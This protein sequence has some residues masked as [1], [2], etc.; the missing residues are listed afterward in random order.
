MSAPENVNLKPESLPLEGSRDTGEGILISIYPDVCLTP[1][2]GVM[3]AIPYT[4][5]AYQSDDAN[6]AATVRQTS[7]RSHTSASIITHCYGDEAGT[8]GGVTLG[9]HNSI[10][11]PKTWSP[12]VRFEGH[13]AVRHQDEWWMNKRNTIGKLTYIKDQNQYKPPKV[14]LRTVPPAPTEKSGVY[15]D[16]TPDAVSAGQQYARGLL[17]EPDLAPN[18]EFPP[19]IPSRPAIPPATTP[20]TLPTAPQPGSFPPSNPQPVPG[21]LP[22]LPGNSPTPTIAPSWSIPSS[23]LPLSA[24]E[25]AT[26]AGPIPLKPPAELR[27]PQSKALVLPYCLQPYFYRANGPNGRGVTATADGNLQ[28]ITSLP[29][30]L[31]KVTMNPATNTYY[32]N[33]AS[34]PG[35]EGFFFGSSRTFQEI[36]E[37]CEKMAQ[38]QQVRTTG[39]EHKE[40]PCIV[41]AYKDIVQKCANA[42]CDGQAHHIVPDYTLRYGTRKQGMRGDN[43]IA[44]MPSFDD[45]AAICLEGGAKDDGS[46]HWEAHGADGVIDLLGKNAP[47]AGTAPIGEIMTFSTWQT[48][49][50]SRNDPA[51]QELIRQQVEKSFTGVNPNAPGRTTLQPPLPRTPAYRVLSTY[52]P[53]TFE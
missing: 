38:A 30:P 48:Q 2:G 24:P 4:I 5:Y 31:D 8:G 27:D 28:I 37:I 9:T 52:R 15:S 23:P 13:G 6:T 41:G 7:L 40:C 26:Q 18:E 14:E 39:K 17:V 22:A 51:C 33:A 34:L 20:Q 36:Q 3:V 12:T 1:V 43:R 42:N 25:P 10:C 19:E 53:G 32:P 46:A 11:E 44:G 35:W 50:A 47:A 21:D 45:G 49:W 29:P 16:A